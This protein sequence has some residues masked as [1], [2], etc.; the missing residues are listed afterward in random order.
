M[1]LPN[2][3]LDSLGTIPGFQKVLLLVVIVGG[4]GAGFY[5]LVVLPD[6]ELV[7]SLQE[8]IGKLDKEIQGQR[9]L[10]K[11]LDDL[12]QTAKQLEAELDKKKE[13][14]PPEQE[15]ASLLKQISDLGS[16]I[17]LEF[18]L[19]KPGNR[20]EDAS[21]LFVRLPVSVE[22]AGSYHT[23]TT[24]FDKITKLAQ[25]INVSDVR[26]GSP[27]IEKD[28]VVIQTV[29]ELTAYVAPFEQKH[30]PPKQP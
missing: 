23:V 8:E 7:E 15:A 18:K 1:Q 12:A 10:A 9:L 11:H 25:I 20:A 6:T 17:G 14:L 13:R 29:F 24:F 2:V 5:N 3:S 16:E 28:R 19:W 4:I 30:A 26:M 22:V 21:K 27:K